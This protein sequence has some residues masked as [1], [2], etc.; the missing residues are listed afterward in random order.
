MGA[1]NMVHFPNA[2]LLININE[3]TN[4][5]GQ[6]RELKNVILS[7]VTQTQKYPHGIYSLIS[8]Y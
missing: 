8:G 6:W 4:F 3:I 7:G 1:D 5:S 2:I